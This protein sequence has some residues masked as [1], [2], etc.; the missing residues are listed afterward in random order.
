MEKRK[1]PGKRNN[2][3]RVTNS[4]ML[5]DTRRCSATGFTLARCDGRSSVT[6]YVHADK[7][8]Y[9]S[10]AGTRFCLEYFSV[11]TSTCQLNAQHPSTVIRY[12]SDGIHR[13]HTA[14]EEIRAIC[15]SAHVGQEFSR[16]TEISIRQGC[17]CNCTE[18]RQISDQSMST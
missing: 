12:P 9:I 8:T 13:N 6:T 15:V 14:C 3:T 11:A 17:S 5:L 4:A 7:R 16:C 10:V 18:L 2:Y 1:V